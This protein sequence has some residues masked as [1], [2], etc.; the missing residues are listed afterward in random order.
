MAGGYSIRLS[1]ISDEIECDAPYI[2]LNLP[3]WQKERKHGR[4]CAGDI[5]AMGRG[6][7]GHVRGRCAIGERLQAQAADAN[8]HH[9]FTFQPYHKDIRETLDYYT[10]VR[11]TLGQ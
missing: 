8:D 10:L 2:M 11:T 6:V 3:S 4:S 1:V 9:S 5:V 7:R